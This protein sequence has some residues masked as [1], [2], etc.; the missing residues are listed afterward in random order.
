MGSR[1]RR[2]RRCGAVNAVLTTDRF[3]KRQLGIALGERS[4]SVAEAVS[5]GG[6][7]AR[8]GGA[9]MRVE[10]CAEFA[11]PS[12]VTLE[13]GEELGIHPCGLGARDTLRLEMGYPLH[14]NDIS[15]GRTPLEAGLTWAVSMDKGDFTGRAALARQKEE[16]IP[17]RLWGL[18]MK[19]RLIP[20]S[21]YPVYASGEQVG[22]TT[23][24]GF[25]PTLAIGIAMAYLAPRDRFTAG[26]EVEI[27]VRGRRGTAEVVKPPF[28]QSSPK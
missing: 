8:G 13:R 3:R 14:G 12:G 6:G 18:K 19:D 9:A 10:R 5:T 17:A 11:Y 26:Q 16:G 15:P 28:V 23:S 22:E 20:R 2:R 21:H 25:S 7:G 24:G 27:D 1:P 4:L